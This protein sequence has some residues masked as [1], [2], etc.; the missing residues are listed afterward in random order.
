[1]SDTNKQYNSK[2][3]RR[4]QK[5]T[6]NERVT[7]RLSDALL[8]DVEKIAQKDQRSLSEVIRI[9]LGRCIP[10]MKKEFGLA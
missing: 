6:K 5:T 10:E 1:M 3:N 7:I 8:D 9:A 4:N 2:M